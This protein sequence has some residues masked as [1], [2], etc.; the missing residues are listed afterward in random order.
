[1]NQ[2]WSK[3]HQKAAG[4]VCLLAALSCVFPKISVF[5]FVAL[6]ICS[7]ALP[8][9]FSFQRPVWACLIIAA[10]A[11][12]TFSFVK[13]VRTDAIFGM[14]EQH[15]KNASRT[16]RSSLRH[17]IFA[18]DMMR[19]RGYIDHDKDGIGSAGF[20][21]ELVGGSALPDGS[22]LTAPLLHQKYKKT[23]DSPAG[24]LVEAEGY[25]FKICLPTKQNTFVS[26]RS[27][28]I[29]EEKAERRFLAYAWPAEDRAGVHKA[30]F[31]DERERIYI[32]ENQPPRAYV[33]LK[34]QPSCDA[35]L[36]GP[37]IDA[38]P[39]IDGSASNDGLT[40][41]RWRNK[42]PRETLIGDKS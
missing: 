4:I 34:Q 10:F 15:N 3:S 6:L 7:F 8:N 37:G 26:M 28:N 5:T 1:M 36:K 17:I 20:M 23:L 11:A 18:Q 31:L 40:W 9:V 2:T 27:P 32:L 29:D 30:F 39:P 12:H 14:I 38:T 19:E 13:F 25:L 35:T 42:K 22:T 41:K 16:A 21:A 24:K 33:G